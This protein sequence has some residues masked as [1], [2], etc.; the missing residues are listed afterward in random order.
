MSEVCGGSL[1]GAG[2]QY[3]KVGNGEF[4]A[5][6]GS[7][8]HDRLNLST[9]RIPWKQ[10]LKGSVILRP[11]QTNYLLNHLG[12]GDNATFLLIR[13]KYDDKSKYEEDNYIEWSYYDD[14]TRI[15]HMA[16]L[17]ILTGN[18]KKRI[19][20][21]FLTNPNERY[22]V[23][24]EVMV[25]VIDDEYSFFNNTLDQTGT[26][27]VNLILGAI[28]THIVGESIVIVDKNDDPL[29]YLNLSNIQSIE[30]SGLILIIDDTSIG[31]IFLQ[32]ETEEDARQAHSLINYVLLNNNI[33]INTLDPLEDNEEPIVYFYDKVNGGATPSYIKLNGATAGPYN[34]S[35][36]LTFSSELLLSDF[37]GEI[38]KELLTDLLIQY[39]EDNRDGLIT[40]TDD[41]IILSDGSSDI[42]VISA[43]GSY[44][45]TFDIEDLA[46]NSVNKDITF[47]L[48]IN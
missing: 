20:Q 35:D 1:F 19:P 8:V 22:P 12:L 21:L 18:S 29:I 3:I 26:S 33:D 25:G 16:Q 36:G 28:K 47:S 9:L 4:V 14:L 46:G 5:V 15:N 23:H 40:L 17:M 37:S 13:A 11:G 43:T 10:L 34:T 24:L 44:S 42:S 6:K 27:F 32:F 2:A 45:F 7:N 39:T 30:R 38:D 41:N 31:K 48:K